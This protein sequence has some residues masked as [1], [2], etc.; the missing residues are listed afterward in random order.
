MKG[1]G[2]VR[3]PERKEAAEHEKTVVFLVFGGWRRCAKHKKHAPTGR[4]V[5][6]RQKGR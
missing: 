3:L 5:C 4:V 1:G 6:F 2:A